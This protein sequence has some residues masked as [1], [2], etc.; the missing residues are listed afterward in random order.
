[1]RGGCETEVSGCGHVRKVL[2]TIP[3]CSYILLLLTFLS[4]RYHIADISYVFIH[5]P[6]NQKHS[7]GISLSFLGVVEKPRT[8]RGIYDIACNARAR[9]FHPNTIRKVRRLLLSLRLA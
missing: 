4:H 9:T 1:M 2:H 7:K 6:V 8:F 5:M 3:L